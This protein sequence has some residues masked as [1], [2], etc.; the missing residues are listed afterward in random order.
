MPTSMGSNG[1]P[2]KWITNSILGLEGAPG[3]GKSTVAR[4]LKEKYKI[5]VERRISTRE[6]RPG[7]GDEE[8]IFETHRDFRVMLHREHLLRSTMERRG[9]HGRSFRTAYRTP[10]RWDTPPEG[11]DLILFQ[12]ATVPLIQKLWLP[13]MITVYIAN[14]SSY[15][16]MKQVW[17][18]TR[19]DGREVNDK[20]MEIDQYWRKSRIMEW[21]FDKIVLN[22]LASPGE[23]P[24]EKCTQEI[25]KLLDLD[26]WERNG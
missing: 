8:Y 19:K 23:I 11:I 15:Q 7:E 6:R 18:R 9:E 17:E 22:P 3:S 16:N 4:I 14:E 20:L 21:A 26:M 24:G 5:H 13:T 1:F 12:G 2:E 10:D 25:A